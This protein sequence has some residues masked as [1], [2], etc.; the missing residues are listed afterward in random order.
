M[1]NEQEQ[2]KKLIKEIET[3]FDEIK[4]LRDNYTFEEEM[5]FEKVKEI[6]LAIGKV[7]LIYHKL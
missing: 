4:Y 2:K 1:V 5:T 7:W 6:E 3:C